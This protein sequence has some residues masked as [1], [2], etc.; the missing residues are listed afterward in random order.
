MILACIALLI[1][2]LIS[3]ILSFAT[4]Y[5]NVNGGLEFLTSLAVFLALGA[6]KAS[7]GGLVAVWIAALFY[8][9][10]GVWTVVAIPA[11]MIVAY[12]PLIIFA[13][14]AG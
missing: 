5:G 12:F 10:K 1:L 6:L 13:W 9:W 4:G 14:I 7:L 3:A 11:I 2:A 8:G